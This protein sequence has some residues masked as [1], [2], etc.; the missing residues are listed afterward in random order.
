MN[1]ILVL[2]L[3]AS[4]LA[5]L[6][7][8]KD[9]I[10]TLKETAMKTN[11]SIVATLTRQIA[12]ILAIGLAVNILMVSLVLTGTASS[13]AHH[14]VV[15]QTN[16]AYEASFQSWKADQQWRVA[17][18]RRIAGTRGAD[19]TPVDALITVASEKLAWE[20]ANS[21]QANENAAFD[22]LSTFEAMEADIKAIQDRWMER[23]QNW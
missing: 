18:D 13:L 19:A 17:A 21:L 6:F 22:A 15:G 1:T 14:F 2:V 5:T 23:I 11:S 8:V 4:I 10:D 20:K 12:G 9:H 16:T 7:V 3:A